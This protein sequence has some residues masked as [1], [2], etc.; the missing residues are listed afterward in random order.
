VLTVPEVAYESLTDFV[1]MAV[2]YLCLDVCGNRPIHRVENLYWPGSVDH[3]LA[4]VKN[5]QR[6]AVS[7]S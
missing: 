2:G 5:E 3:R 4:K 1:N 7:W 6:F